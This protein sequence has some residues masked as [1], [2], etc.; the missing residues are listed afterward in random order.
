MK[1]T[2]AEPFLVGKVDIRSAGPRCRMLLG[3]INQDGRMEIVMVQPDNRQ[4]VCHIPHQVQCVTVFDLDGH[5]LWQTGTPSEQAGGPGSDY[6]AQIYDIDGDGS[7]EVLCIMNDRFHILDGATG[8][9]K[10]VYELPDPQAHDC[11]IIANLTGGE[12]ASDI[13]LKD[14]YHRLWALDKDFRLLWTH[15]G[16]IGHFPWAHDLNGDGYDEI[17]AGYDLLDRHGHVQWSCQPLEDHADCI[18]VG[19]VNGDGEKELVIGGSVTVMYDR[20]GREL[21]RFDG[22]VESQHVALGKFREDLPGLQ[23]AGLDRLIREDN[24][25][26][27]KGKDAL[28]LLDANGKQLWKEDR[29]TSGWLTIIETLRNWADG[30]LDYI[31]AYRRG[32]GIYPTLYDGHMNEVV[33]F[34]ADGYVVHADLTGNGNEQVIVYDDNTASIFSSKQLSLS[35]SAATAGALPQ[36]K[37]MYSSTLYPGGER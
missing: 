23:I 24:R 14:R 5:M 35:A 28:F 19:D 8:A 36:S 20:N 30:S 37:L 27:K 4:N 22:S 33:T 13:L 18:W 16:N 3:D 31:L 32:G 11:I 10:A 1:A 2:K 21:W 34:P 26:G 7:L 15:Q 6:P 17:M 25:S 9:D 12:R 29:Q